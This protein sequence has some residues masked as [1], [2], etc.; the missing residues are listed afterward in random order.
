M[1]DPDD[2]VVIDSNLE[3]NHGTTAEGGGRARRTIERLTYWLELLLQ[4]VSP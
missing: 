2:R 1:V 4:T 3:N